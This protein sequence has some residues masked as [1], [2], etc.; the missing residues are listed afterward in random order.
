MKTQRRAGKTA[1]G[2]RALVILQDD[3]GMVLS[4]YVAP[5]DHP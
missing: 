4:T 1:P 5:N 2:A 3:L